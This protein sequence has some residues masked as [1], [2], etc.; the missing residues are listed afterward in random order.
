VLS[1]NAA[2]RSPN[3]VTW[4]HKAGIGNAARAPFEPDPDLP[5]GMAKVAPNV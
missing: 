2:K 1:Y 4:L 5:H 3:W